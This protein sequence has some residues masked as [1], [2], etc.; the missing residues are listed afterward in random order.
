MMQTLAILR[1]AGGDPES[2]LGTKK[3][4]RESGS[5]SSM[6]K[7]AMNGWRPKRNGCEFT[8]VPDEICSLPTK[9]CSKM[10]R[11]DATR[12]EEHEESGSVPRWKAKGWMFV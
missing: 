10:S 5:M 7:K 2:R 11:A 6:A 3:K 8:V 9:L 12:P 1:V 4:Q